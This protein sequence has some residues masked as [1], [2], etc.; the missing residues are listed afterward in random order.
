[1]IRPTHAEVDLSAIED[2]IR[3]IRAKVGKK[4]KIIPAVKADGYG[5]GAVETSKAVL[6]AS[7]DALAVAIIEEAIELREAGILNVP[8]LMLGCST[9]DVIPEIVHYDTI[10]AACNYDFC[11]RLSEEALKQ[12]KKASVH[13]KVDTGMGRIG[14]QPDDTI[15]FAK[16]LKALEGLSVDGLFTH[17]PTSD[18]TDRAF[19]LTQISTVKKIVEGLSRN[20]IKIPFVHAANSGAILAFPEAYFDA[21]RPGIIVYGQYPSSEVPHTVKLREAMT[22]KTKIV[23]IKKAAKGTTISYG[24]THTLKRESVVATIPIGYADGYSRL[25][26]NKG[27]AAVNGIRVPVIGRICMDQCMLDVTDVSDVKVG[28][29]VVLYGGGYDYLSTTKIADK[30][31][32]ISYEVLCAISK[33]VPRV[34]IK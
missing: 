16:K 8:I 12:G 31:G 3:G 28:D 27:D 14:V 24:R 17:F 20:G 26:S 25:L 7:A 6:R 10:S 5:H 13:I 2:N 21:V 15:E 9:D 23:F 11:K 32:T 19:T 29:D 18:E 22:L 1:M 30:I 33:R 4:A 34:Y